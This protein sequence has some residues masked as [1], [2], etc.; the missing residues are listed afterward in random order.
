MKDGDHI[1]DRQR[2]IIQRVA[3]G[4]DW[5]AAA[6]AEGC[7]DTYSRVIRTRMMK[8][9][10]VAKAIE[11]IR[12]EGRTAAAYDLARA[13]QEAQEVI[14]FAKQHKHPTAYFF[15]V[16]HRAHL[17]GLLVDKIQL[18]ATVDLKGALTEARSRVITVINPLSPHGQ[19]SAT[20]VLTAAPATGAD[21]ANVSAHGGKLWRP[22]SGD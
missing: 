3:R 12:A 1:P 13:M 16:R 20:M 19:E 14:E 6:M 9:P 21:P 15:A 10:E 18:E 8:N 11:A 22:F 2:R 17:S 4:E 5:R 7:S